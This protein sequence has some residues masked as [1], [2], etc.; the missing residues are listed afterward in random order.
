M[1]PASDMPAWTKS[2]AHLQDAFQAAL[3][4]F[5]DAQRRQMFGYPAAF[6]N[7]HMWT[8]L[9]QANWVV[10]LPDAARTELFTIEGAGPFE[11][12]PGRPMTGFAT[13]PPS[14]LNDPAQRNAWLTRAWEHALGLSPKEPKAAKAAKS[15]PGR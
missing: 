10:R 14:V 7:G 15:A 12:M 5:P 2:P 3:E 13:L 4:H 8:G 9:H 6:A 1:S 11:P